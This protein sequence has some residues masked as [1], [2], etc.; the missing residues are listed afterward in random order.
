MSSMG[1]AFV[2]SLPDF[3]DYGTHVPFFVAYVFMALLLDVFL[4]CDAGLG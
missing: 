4:Q 1:F 2:D 3:G